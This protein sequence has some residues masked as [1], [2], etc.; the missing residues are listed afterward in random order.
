MSKAYPVRRSLRQ[1][2]CV[3]IRPRSERAVSRRLGGS[4]GLKGS[5]WGFRRPPATR[6]VLVNIVVR[7]LS[8]PHGF[9][10]TAPWTCHAASPETSNRGGGPAPTRRT[11]SATA[12]GKRRGPLVRARPDGGGELG[13]DQLLEHPG[14]AGTDLVGHLAGLDSPRSSDRSESVKATGV[15]LLCVDPGRN[16]PRLT[17]VAHPSGGPQSQL[18]HV[19]GRNI[20][21][22]LV[23]DGPAPSSQF[24]GRSLLAV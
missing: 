2:A 15:D 16:T 6:K 17:P 22:Y 18:H 21:P 12:C 13:L 7:L 4:N 23:V 19:K 8:Y 9:T 14:Q 20:P 24:R 1:A 11:A 5:F 3:E 10:G